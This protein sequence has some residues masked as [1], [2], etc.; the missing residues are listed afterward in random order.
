M[1]HLIR[2]RVFVIGFVIGIILCGL[3]NYWTHLH[4]PCNE[5]IYDCYWFVGFP[6][7]F[8]RVQGG[9]TV[10]DGFIWLGLITD[11]SF[12]ITASVFVGWVF[13]FV[14]QRRM[15]NY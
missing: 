15:K 11:I 1:K 7:P 9:Y 13:W 3:L 2:T 14:D 10:I 4:D 8:L 5:N 12:A 6:A